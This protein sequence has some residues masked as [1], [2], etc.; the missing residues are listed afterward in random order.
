MAVKK[1][2]CDKNEIPREVMVQRHL[3]PHP[4]VLPLFGITHNQD[5]FSLYI[6][7]ELADTSLY[8]YLH[9]EK[10]KKKPSVQQSTKWAIQIARGMHHIHQHKVAHRDLKSPNIL[11]F[12]KADITKICDFGEARSLED[13]TTMTGGVG[14]YRWMAPELNK[15]T[16]TKASQCCD[17]FSYGM[18]LYEIYGHKVPFGDLNEVEAMQRIC[19]EERPPIPPELP[20]HIEKLIQSCWKQKPD[21]R[22]TF[23][24]ILQVCHIHLV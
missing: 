2:D 6:C 5:G 14:T 10:E 19:A 17:V 4:N 21:D 13:T 8:H 24:D 23:G 15:S 18:I 11:L 9:E 22:P 20:P 3:P 12:Q 7:M 1:M 16:N